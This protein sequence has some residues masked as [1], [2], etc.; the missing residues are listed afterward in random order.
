[1]IGL[2]ILVVGS[3]YFLLAIFITFWL[4]SRLKKTI[5]QIIV[6]TFVA[7]VFV[8]IPTWDI[9]PGRLYFSHLCET[10]GGL[11]IYKQVELPAEYWD[12]NG[13]PKFIKDNGDVDKGTLD[14]F[15]DFIVEKKMVSDVFHIQLV[16]FII[17]EKKSKTHVGIYSSFG[18]FGGWLVNNS[19]IHVRGESCPDPNKRPAFYEAILLKVARPNININF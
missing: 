11:K 7:T 17:K 13:K 18:Y 19:G 4:A 10:E 16:N 15:F 8:L 3:I 9:I 14:I 6:F 5:H 2:Y 12:E 1:M